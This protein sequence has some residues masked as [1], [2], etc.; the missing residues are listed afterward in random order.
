MLTMYDNI[1]QL[2]HVLVGKLN[3]CSTNHITSI[4]SKH[5]SIILPDKVL[6]RKVERVL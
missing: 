6:C 4:N 5:L 2:I 3:I 1:L